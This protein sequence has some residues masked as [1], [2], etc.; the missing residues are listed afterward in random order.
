MEHK[1][2]YMIM[3]ISVIVFLVCVLA[4]PDLSQTIYRGF[5]FLR[6]GIQILL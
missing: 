4:C 1:I 6:W 2:K 5:R 3:I